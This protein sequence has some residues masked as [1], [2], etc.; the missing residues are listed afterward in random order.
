MKAADCSWFAC[1]AV[2]L[3]LV[4]LVSTKLIQEEI[5]NWQYLCSRLWFGL[6]ADLRCAADLKLSL[7]AWKNG[8]G[9]SEA[10]YKLVCMV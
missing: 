10:F 6:M 4:S 5:V 1:G 3:A 9:G 7:L 2:A 8:V